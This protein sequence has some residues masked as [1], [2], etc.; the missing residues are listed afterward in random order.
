MVYQKIQPP[1]LSD[2]IAEQLEQMIL[3]GSLESG[4][5]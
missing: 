3:E 2:A 5:R 4:Q 1:K